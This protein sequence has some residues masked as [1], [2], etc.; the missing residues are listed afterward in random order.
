MPAIPSHSLASYLSPHLS[1]R[2]KPLTFMPAGN[3]NLLSPEGKRLTNFVSNDYLG[4]ASEPKMLQWLA[5]FVT[6]P[7]GKARNR[8]SGETS[9]E[10]VSEVGAG[11][12]RLLCANSQALEELE[13]KFADFTNYAEAVVFPSASQANLTIWEAILKP[14]KQAVVYSD[15]Y[16]HSSINQGLKLARA[17]VRHFHHSDLEHLEKLLRRDSEGN[18]E[19]NQGKAQGNETG[20]NKASQNETGKVNPARFIV[21]DTIFSMEG[22]CA[23]LDRLERL[24]RNYNAFLVLDDAHGFGVLGTNGR[25]LANGRGDIAILGLGK[26]AGLWGGVVLVKDAFLKCYLMNRCSGIV[27]TTAVSP[28]LVRLASKMLD[29]IPTLEAR[30]HKLKGYN[31]YIRQHLPQAKGDA[32]IISIILGEKTAKVSDALLAKGFYAKPIFSPTVPRGSERLR[33]SLTA[34]HRKQDI[35]DLVAALQASI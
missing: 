33:L 31:R 32:Q 10:V 18:G 19:T 27:Y 15:I 12:S 7:N 14:L 35:Q 2:A 28:L 30:R 11:S 25:G 6:H 3:G 4:L 16:N 24:A 1:K 8:T 20:I 5:E 13:R 22:D 34:H 26:G 21:T 29:L 17:R 23:D 9:S